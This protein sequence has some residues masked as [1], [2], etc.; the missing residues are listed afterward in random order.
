MPDVLDKGAGADTLAPLE[1]SFEPGNLG[2]GPTVHSQEVSLPHTR[3]DLVRK[4]TH[5]FGLR[6]ARFVYDKFLFYIIIAFFSI[7]S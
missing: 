2:E 5:R 7:S 1:T 4:P 3:D 6:Q